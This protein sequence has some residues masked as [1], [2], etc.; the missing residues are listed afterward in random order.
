M[1]IPY[2]ADFSLNLRKHQNSYFSNTIYKKTK[3]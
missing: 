3:K 1:Y 2:Q